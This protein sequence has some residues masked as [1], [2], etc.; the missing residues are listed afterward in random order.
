MRYYVVNN[1]EGEETVFDLSGHRKLKGGV[2][3]M[4]A[5][6][7]AFGKKS[8]YVR[9]LAGNNYISFDNQRWEKLGKIKGLDGLINVTSNLNVYRGFKPSGIMGASAGELVTDM[10]GKVVKLLTTEGAMVNEGDT[11]MILEAMKM[12]NEIKAGVSGVVKAVHIKEGQVLEAGTLMIE[13]E[14]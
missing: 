4:N 5:A 11:L 7:A 12:E 1:Q 14:Q 6:S 8:V 2:V 9:N 10:P 13:I 3:A